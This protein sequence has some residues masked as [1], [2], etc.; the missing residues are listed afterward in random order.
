[1]HDI[2]EKQVDLESQHYNESIQCEK[3]HAYQEYNLNSPLRVDE[4]AEHFKTS[5]MN[6]C[7]NS[8]EESNTN[9]KDNDEAI[10]VSSEES[11]CDTK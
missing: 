11:E 10:V 1:M 3:K 4:I 2:N 5:L 8:Q 7:H 6:K 9:V